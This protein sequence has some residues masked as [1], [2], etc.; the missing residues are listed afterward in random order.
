MKYFFLS[1]FSF[2][3]I[4]ESSQAQDWQLIWEDTFDGTQLDSSKWAHDLG[5]GTQY[6]LWGW[7]NGELQCYQEENTIVSD[8]TL[9]I[10]AK[11]EPEGVIDPYNSSNV[12][13]YSS[14]KIITAELFTFRYGRVQARIKTVDG[15]GFWPA[16]WMLPSGGS[17]PCDGEI[18][19]MEQ[20]GNNGPSNVTTGAAHLGPCSAGGS[21]YRSFSKTLDNGSYAD[22]FH[23]YE[24]RWEPDRITWY[25]DGE[26][27]FNVTPEDYPSDY[28]WPFNTGDWFLMLN[29]A[30][31]KNGPSAQTQF[32]SQI[33]VDWVRVYQEN[34]EGADC[35]DVTAYNYNAEATSDD[36]SCLYEVN[37]E[38][39]M[40][41]S[42]L[43]PKVVTVT[44]LEQGADCTSGIVLY[45]EDNSRIW[46][47]TTYLR[48]GAH[49][50]S[51]C[52][53]GGENVETLLS[54][55]QSSGNWS[56]VGNT[57]STFYAQRELTVQSAQTVSDV[58]SS[59]DACDG[60]AGCID[61]NATNY[62]AEASIHAVDEN[63]GWWC[64]YASCEKVPFDGCLWSD[65]FFPFTDEVVISQCQLNYGGLICMSNS[66]VEYGCLDPK[67]QNYNASATV[68]ATDQWENILCTYASCDDVP[69][70][71][72]MYPQAFATFHSN[73]NSANCSTYGGTPCTD[74]SEGCL[75]SNALNY[76][77]EA[78]V[79]AKDQ[80]QNNLCTYASC[81]D[82]PETGC[83][84]PTA[85]ATFNTNFG[86][87]DCENYGGTACRDASEGCIDPNASD[88]NSEAITQAY[89]QYGNLMCTYA[90]CNEVPVEG[91]C[92]YA[93]SFGPWH[94]LFGPDEC[95]S[96]SGEPCMSSTVGCIDPNAIDYV[97]GATTQT[98][99][100]NGN[101]LC[102]YE[103]CE[104]VPVE[105]GCLYKNGLGPWTD[106][107]NAEQCETYTGTA[108]LS[109][110]SVEE[111]TALFTL[112]PNPSEGIFRLSAEE[113]INELSV[114]DLTGHLVYQQNFQSKEVELD[115]TYLSTG[116]YFLN[117]RFETK[118]SYTKTLFRF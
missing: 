9:K 75:D 59:C 50:Y 22:D 19:I 13:D 109:R 17:W 90:S 35:T 95:S 68:Q 15:Q 103:S 12:K 44:G 37:F 34:T 97:T 83:M 42:L 76:N 69:E 117:V 29:L 51:Y 24:I 78:T 36:G 57:D 93:N 108:C 88:Y 45:E 84:Y 92:K 67:A 26:Y 61:P 54:Y 113:K 111:L 86:A 71:G 47:G 33:E 27:L 11:H 3:F 14:S 70:T 4:I 101:I 72:C 100:A 94:G 32:P 60:E 1:L 49:Q 85:F 46:K 41:C 5:T 6:G 116:S 73:F 77:A 74:A 114:Y 79:Q 106:G 89:D 105:G 16:F 107:F 38:L 64:S 23:T 87:S 31:D 30:I 40:R 43:D 2:F 62:D 91:G 81:E 52:T 10:I 63:G 39:D 112:H 55:A 53:D 65:Y 110:V 102:R 56:C 118:E 7:G 104:E 58:W 98:Y 8:G 82:V 48:A 80:W 20:W 99:D 96:Y 18:D 66:Y 21:T 115:L 25:V 28:T